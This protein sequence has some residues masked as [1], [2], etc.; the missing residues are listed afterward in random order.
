MLPSGGASFIPGR[1]ERPRI[2]KFRSSAADTRIYRKEAQTPTARILANKV[3]VDG[4][5]A[6]HNMSPHARSEGVRRNTAG[7]SRAIPVSVCGPN[8]PHAQIICRRRQFASG[9]VLPSRCCRRS[10]RFIS[11]HTTW[12][13]YV[14][15]TWS[16]SA[17]VWKTRIVS[18]AR[19][20]G[21]H[22]PSCFPW[23]RLNDY[24]RVL[25][26]RFR[27]DWLRTRRNSRLFSVSGCGAKP[28]RCLMIRKRRRFIPR[29][30]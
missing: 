18:L 10:P 1:K 12:R 17:S 8:K 2:R 23:T 27:S 6:P 25:G 26:F 24:V 22:L 29:S 3:S 16:E 4:S 19:C 9:T 21:R 30:S 15:R 11:Y 13:S 7:A 14:V 20:L 5:D 28:L